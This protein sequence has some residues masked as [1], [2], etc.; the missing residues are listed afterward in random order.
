MMEVLFAISALAIFVGVVI[1]G[2]YPVG[3]WVLSR[4]RGDEL[5]RRDP[6]VPPLVSV[7][8]AT[9]DSDASID[10]RVVNL[11]DTDHPAAA[12]EIV[13]A[14]DAEPGSR[15][16][17]EESA[18]Q[19]GLRVVYA[20]SPGGKALSLNAGVHAATGE[21]LVMADCAQRYD[22][23]TIPEL[24][25]HLEDQRFGAVSGALELG[26]SQRLTPVGLYW[27]LEKWLRYHEGRVHSTVGVTGAVYGV[28]RALWPQLP[29]GTL[30]D[31][32]YVPMSLVL[33]G[34]RVGFTYHARAVDTRHLDSR[35]E[36][37]RKSRTLTGVLQL[38]QL[39]PAILSRNNPI[40]VQFIMHKLARLATPALLILIVATSLGG[41]APLA[42]A[43]PGTLAR[44]LG[45]ATTLI[46]LVPP[47][48]RGLVSI[49]LWIVRLQGAVAS[50]LRNGVR[51]H[52]SVWN[53]KL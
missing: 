5:T 17:V 23:R 40:R 46:A 1:W 26:N 24:V 14:L 32:V 22:R 31:D 4:L 39:M 9:R 47:L 48:R 8:F 44:A 35:A 6:A 13:V 38:C 20:T 3:V 50:A 41:L 15:P 25:A 33:R 29:A 19:R 21:I 37:A 51:R 43:H 18:A 12:L 7:I 30:L 45:A 34:H 28:R 36:A 52:W 53:S 27:R 11:L 2:G 16:A 10:D 49:V 42:Y